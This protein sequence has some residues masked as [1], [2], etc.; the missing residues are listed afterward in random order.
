MNQLRVFL[1]ETEMLRKRSRQEIGK[2]LGKRRVYIVAK[3]DIVVECT[4]QWASVSLND[5]LSWPTFS[6]PQTETNRV[7]YV[8]M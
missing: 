2:A 5:V 3:L 8:C 4:A 7:G 1:I 6:A